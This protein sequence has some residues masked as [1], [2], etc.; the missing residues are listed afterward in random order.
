M[1]R[2]GPLP[3]LDFRRSRSGY[4][5][6]KLNIHS[7]YF[8][9][10]WRS[11]PNRC[12]PRRRNGHEERCA[13]WSPTPSAI[14]EIVP[15][16]ESFA[17]PTIRSPRAVLTGETPHGMCCPDRAA[18]WRWLARWT[19]K[20]TLFLGHFLHLGAT[21]MSSTR[22]TAERARS[23]GVARLRR[24]LHCR[25]VPSHRASADVWGTSSQH[26]D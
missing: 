4:S 17:I 6:Y 3:T 18:R 19:P 25:D 15:E 8:D 2:R 13:S 26:P 5:A 1:I 24:L 21:T 9:T 12:W 16:Q 23:E 20:S 11:S 22:Q 14:T 7:P 10:H